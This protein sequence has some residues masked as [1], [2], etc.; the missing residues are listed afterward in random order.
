MGSS[1]FQEVSIDNLFFV[2]KGQ[3][4]VAINKEM[5]RITILSLASLNIRPITHTFPIS[6][7]CHDMDHIS[8]YCA[9]NRFEAVSG[10]DN[11]APFTKS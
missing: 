1:V 5:G 3:E 2:R 9:S 6:C 4:L 7:C 11:P 8:A 10:P